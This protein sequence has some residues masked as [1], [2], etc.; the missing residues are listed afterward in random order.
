ML[1][2][3]MDLILIPDFVFLYFNPLMDTF[4]GVVAIPSGLRGHFVIVKV[5][6]V[7]SASPCDRLDIFKPMIILRLPIASVNGGDILKYL[8]LILI[9]KSEIFKFL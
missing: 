2:V 1:F 3:S 5:H 4:R 8:F 7:L 9:F 6:V